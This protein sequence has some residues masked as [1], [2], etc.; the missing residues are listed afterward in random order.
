M[1]RDLRHIPTLVTFIKRYTGVN[2]YYSFDF[3]VGFK[4]FSFLK[5]SK[6]EKD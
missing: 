6:G 5:K 2:L 4:F 3:S 1:K